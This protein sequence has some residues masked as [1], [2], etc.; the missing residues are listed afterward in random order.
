M[1]QESK[2]NTYSRRTALQLGGG[3]MLA[4]ILAA[5]GDDGGEEAGATS[6]V[7]GGEATPVTSFPIVPGDVE[8]D[9]HHVVDPPGTA[10]DRGCPRSQRPTP[11]HAE[12]PSS[13]VAGRCWR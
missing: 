1:P 5:C 2:T 10:G 6:G 4:L 11:T 9:P 7:V 13:S 12:R 3:T 8:W